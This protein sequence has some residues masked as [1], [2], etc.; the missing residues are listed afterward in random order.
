LLSEVIQ[1]NEET[2]SEVRRLVYGLRP[3][4]L[5]ELG[6][7]DSL[8]TEGEAILGQVAL[9]VTLLPDPLPSL[10]AAVEV[11]VYRIALEALNNVSRHAQAERCC[12]NI[13]ITDQLCL[14]VEDDGRGLPAQVSPGVGLHSMRERT[15][16]LDGTFSATKLAGGGTR[17]LATLPLAKPPVNGKMP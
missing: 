12:L 8:R 1:K 14:T 16:E 17:I 10:P 4:T 15:S 9:E 2:V 11:A 3:P 6:L 5:D 7:V 13:E